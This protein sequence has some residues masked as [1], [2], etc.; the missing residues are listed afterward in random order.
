[1]LAI[2][3][4]DR[5]AFTEPIVIKTRE[6][7]PTEAPLSVHVQSGSFGELIVTWQVRHSTSWPMALS[8]NTQ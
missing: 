7:A 2:N 5:S 8:M 4:I 6:E 1:M 3:E